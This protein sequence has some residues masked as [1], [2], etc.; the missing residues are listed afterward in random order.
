MIAVPN[1]APIV[2]HVIPMPKKPRIGTGKVDLLSQDNKILEGLWKRKPVPKQV[3]VDSIYEQLAAV[4]SLLDECDIRFHLV[5]GSMLGLAR[6]GGLIPWDD[7]VDIG[8]HADDAERLWERRDRFKEF[9]CTLVRAA[10][11][12]KFGPGRVNFDAMED[13][14][15]VPTF[16]FAGG[17]NVLEQVGSSTPFES[18]LAHTD[19]FTFREDGEMDGVPVMRYACERAKELWP[20]EVIPISGWYAKA[21]RVPFGDYVMVPSLPPADLEWSM[22]TAYGLHWRTKNGSGDSISDFSCA[23]HSSL[24]SVN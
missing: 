17:Q 2:D 12:F 15:G 11:G 14:D 18:E 4:T 21:T 22:N 9:G 16:K 13:I 8:I 7:D 10:I 24:S 1:V 6:H 23:R 5:A 20:R 19:I 3:Q